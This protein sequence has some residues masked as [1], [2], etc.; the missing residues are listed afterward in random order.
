MR[1]AC[2]HKCD[3]HP[4]PRVIRA[5]K[6]RDPTNAPGE[7]KR[8]NGPLSVEGEHHRVSHREQIRGV[9]KNAAWRGIAAR[10]PVENLVMPRLSIEDGPHQHL[11]S[12][13]QA[14]ISRSLALL[15]RSA[16][17]GNLER[18]GNCIAHNLDGH[19][20]VRLVRIR[21][22][23]DLRLL[24]PWFHLFDGLLDRR[25]RHA[26]AFGSLLWSTSCALSFCHGSG[27]PFLDD[28][29]K[30]SR[31]PLGP[32]VGRALLRQRETRE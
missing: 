14:L 8:A 5:A 13:R 29:N 7:R 20:G 11:C 32:S 10:G 3:A 26:G 6:R 18:S 19:G 1:L 24:R 21:R 9:N 27:P 12:R 2:A 23:Q 16:V 15:N 28:L 25:R 17:G 22:R 30:R 4:W 31:G